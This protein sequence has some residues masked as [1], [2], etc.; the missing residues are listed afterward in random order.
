[1]SLDTR[2]RP[3]TWDVL[4]SPPLGTITSTAYDTAI[5]AALRRPEGDRQVSWFPAAVEWLRRA[6]HDDGSWGGAVPVAHD[7]LVSTLAAVRALAQEPAPWAPAALRAGVAYL[8]RTADAWRSCPHETVA[9][10][11]VRPFLAEEAQRLGIDLRGLSFSAPAEFTPEQL[12][13]LSPL[14]LAHPLEAVGRWLPDETLRALPAVRGLIGCSP[15]ATAYAWSRLGDDTR[16]GQVSAL[17]DQSPDRG[18]PTLAPIEIFEPAWT[19][20]LLQEVG[21]SAARTARTAMTPQGV[22]FTAGLAGTDSDSTGMVLLVLR[23]AGHDVEP[24]LPALLDFERE[25]HFACFRGER[26]ASVA[27]NARV[28]EVLGGDRR[29]APQ[30]AKVVRYLTEQR[31]DG[32]HWFDKWHVSAYYATAQVVFAAHRHAPRLVDGV[33]DWV[34]GTQRD[35]GSWGTCRGTIEETS[36]A[37]LI[38]RRLGHDDTSAPPTRRALHR[39]GAHLRQHA[40][41]VLADPGD[42][43]L[44][45]PLWVGKGLYGSRMYSRALLLAALAVVPEN[46]MTW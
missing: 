7:R 5:V 42:P 30:T 25:D 34:L 13:R 11:L 23:R 41:D 36:L 39:A 2:E 12:A 21:L 17:L 8:R 29:Y 3:G 37:V 46:G 26:D 27:S 24:M 9:F 19:L 38:L 40:L 45:P 43:V 14:H 18:A 16:H 35:D 22:G 32:S 15:S 6:Q 33:R 28:L 20:Y 1:V 10:R 31:R 4:Q 44:V